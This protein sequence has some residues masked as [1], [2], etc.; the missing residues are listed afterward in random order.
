MIPRILAGL[1]C[2]VGLYRDSQP[3]IRS[4]A[5]LVPSKTDDA[6]ITGPKHLDS[7][8][9]TKPKFLE[10]VDMV[11]VAADATNSRRLACGQVTQGNRLVNH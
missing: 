10:P 11:W 3:I 7:N 4:T 9:T 2:R 1:T 6:R 5:N 8:A